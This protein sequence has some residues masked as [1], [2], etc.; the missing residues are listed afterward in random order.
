MHYSPSDSP[1][2]YSF[3]SDYFSVGDPI[4]EIN[5]KDVTKLKHSEIIKFIQ[6]AGKRLCFKMQYKELGAGTLAYYV[7]FM[8]LFQTII[9]LLR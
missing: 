1:V 5:E 3:R 6:E 2:L 7:D 9:S 4:L 8:L